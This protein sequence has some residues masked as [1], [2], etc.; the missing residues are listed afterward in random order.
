MNNPVTW[1]GYGK[2]VYQRAI[3]RLATQAGVLIAPWF[4]QGASA[5]SVLRLHSGLSSAD[6]AM[7][8]S[9]VAACV[10]LI[11]GNVAKLPAPVYRTR[12]ER[13]TRDRAHPVDMIMNKRPN[14]WQTPFEFRKMMTAR[15]ALYGNAYALK[16]FSGAS[17]VALIPLPGRV[18]VEQAAFDLAPTYLHTSERG[19]DT[20]YSSS[21]IFHLRDLTLDGLNGISRIDQAKQGITLAIASE[22]FATSYF[23]N[24]AEPGVGIEVEGNLDPEQRKA[25]EESWRATHGGPD[26]A[27]G[28]FVM[29]GGAKLTKLGASNKESQML[30]LRGFQVED[31]ARVFGVPPHMIGKTDKQTSYGTGIEMQAL[32]F[33]QFHLLD[34]LVMWESAISRDLIEDDAFLEHNVEG[35]LRADI[36]TRMESYQLAITNGILNPDEVRMLENRAPRKDGKGKEYWRPSNMVGAVE[37]PKPVAPPIIPAAM[38][39]EQPK[40]LWRTK[41]QAAMRIVSDRQTG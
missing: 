14:D 29:E 5:P 41:S 33:L 7:K 2:Y 25:L 27:H 1:F 19:G 18:K 13:R 3:K 35:L 28:P 36:K 20:R 37:Q 11:A 21:E 34:W 6:D 12:G 4:R 16:R 39:G 38:P 32:G 31:I 40:H 30:E 9:A 23:M 22:T 26:R 8:A 17:L 15:V 10:R 24:G